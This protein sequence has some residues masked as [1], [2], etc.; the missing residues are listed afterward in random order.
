MNLVDN[1]NYSECYEDLTLKEVVDLIKNNVRVFFEL[2]LCRYI[3]HQSEIEIDGS[4]IVNEVDSE[5]FINA[6]KFRTITE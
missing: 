5:K 4:L 6:G 2:N 1:P 3:G